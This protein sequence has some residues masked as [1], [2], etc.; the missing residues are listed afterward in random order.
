MYIFGIRQILLNTNHNAVSAL[1]SYAY[2]VALH[3]N[4]YAVHISCIL[5][6]QKVHSV[7]CRCL[8]IWFV[9]S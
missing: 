9:V 1:L 4:E 6:L 7:Q 5:G 2:L 8:D 3:F